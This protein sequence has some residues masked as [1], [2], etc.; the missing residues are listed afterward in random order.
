MKIYIFI[1]VSFLCFH[2]NNTH[3]N[4]QMNAVYNKEHHQRIDSISNAH[5]GRDFEN[6]ALI[7]LN[8][9]GLS[10]NKKL[11]LPIGRNQGLQK[12]HNFDLGSL[13]KK[14]IVECK[15]HR[16]TSGNRVPSA[17]ITTWNQAMYYFSIA[18]NS[19]RKIFFVLKDIRK[20]TGETLAQYYIRTNYHLIPKDVEI[21]EYDEIDH[22]VEKLKTHT[23]N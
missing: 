18:P 14:I 21:F 7:S 5:A 4:N 16:W 23:I 15:S 6:L 20:T 12:N 13:D 22:T 9:Q 2:V 19:F 10:L 11:A 17:K 8:K 3:A 1:I